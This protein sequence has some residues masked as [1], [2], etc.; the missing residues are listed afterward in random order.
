MAAALWCG[1]SKENVDAV[2]NE[3]TQLSSSGKGQNIWS[4]PD[5]PCL[6]PRCLA[7][8]DGME[9]KELEYGR[10]DGKGVPLGEHIAYHRRH[11]LGRNLKLWLQKIYPNE[12]PAFLFDEIERNIHSDITVETYQA[13]KADR[14]ELKVRLDN[15]IVVYKKWQEEKSELELKIEHLKAVVDQQ[16]VPL[17]SSVNNDLSNSL[18]WTKFRGMVSSAVSA[19]PKW[20]A[21]VNKVQKSGNLQD[22]LLSRDDVNSREAEII[23]KV[24]TDFYSELKQ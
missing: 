2:L 19:Y 1:I 14:D 15:A 7:I 11:V 16:L 18:Y 12:R 22:W 17:T 4:H 5:V 10:E 6:E 24:L 9:E 21:G 20:K 3:A 13:L 8:V 23:K